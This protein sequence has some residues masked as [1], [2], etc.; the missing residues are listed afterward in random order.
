MPVPPYGGINGI[1]FWGNAGFLRM[2]R[3]PLFISAFQ[4][5]QRTFKHKEFFVKK[6]IAF[7][8]LALLMAATVFTQTEADFDVK[9]TEDDTGVVITKYTGKTAQVRIPAT[10]Q[11]M[12]VR[13]IGGGA[14]SG[15]TTITGVIIPE[16]VTEIGN[17]AFGRCG[18]LTSITLP[19]TLTTLGES[20]FQ[21]TK[22][23][24]FTLPATLKKIGGGVFYSCTS[25]KTVT[26]SEGIT[27]IPGSI[28]GMFGSCT[29]LTTVTLP[30]TLTTIGRRVFENCT[31]LTAI[32]LP[33]SITT[34]E[35]EAFSGCSALTAV[36]IPS[37]V[38]SIK[39]IQDAFPRCPKLTLASQAA[40]KRVTRKETQIENEWDDYD[41]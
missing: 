16:G 12:P 29:A 17:Y 39:S 34:I 24:T 1:L 27:E 25:L 4:G 10:I 13:E 36:T 6:N 11:E 35:D 5:A 2:E 32:A 18:N 28:Y 23:N 26:I 20:A 7:A 33:A 37:T 19:K 21:Y 40:I 3:H 30:S 9:L 41:Y 15:N 22:I 8:T 14:F 31:A 38:E